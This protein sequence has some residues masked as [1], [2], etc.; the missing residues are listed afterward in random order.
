MCLVL[1]DWHWADPLVGGASRAPDRTDAHGCRSSSGAPAGPIRTPRRRASGRPPPVRAASG[2]SRS[3][4]SRSRR[5]K[6]TSWSRACS[7]SMTFRRGC[8]DLVLAK[9]EGNPFFIEEVVRSLVDVGAIVRDGSDGRWKT[10]PAVELVSIPPTLGGVITARFDRLDEDTKETLRIAAV[11]GRRFPL[12]GVARARPLAAA[13][14]SPGVPLRARGDPREQG[15]GRAR[16]RLQARGHPGGDLRGHPAPSP[17]RAPPRCRRAVRGVVLGSTRRV[18][19]PA[20]APLRVRR[21]VA[22]G[23]A[24][25]AGGGR[26]RRPPRRRRRGARALPAG[27]RG[28]GARGRRRVGRAAMGGP[29]AEDGGGAVPKR[30]ARRGRGVPAP[31]DRPAGQGRSRFAK[32]CAERNP[33]ADPRPGVAPD[34]TALP[35]LAETELRRR[36]RRAR[37]PVR[38]AQLGRLLHR[39]RAVRPRRAARAEPLR[40]VR[41]P[42]RD[43]ARVARVRRALRHGPAPSAGAPLPRPS[44]RARR[45]VRR[46]AAS[47]RGVPPP[48]DARALQRGRLGRRGRA[49]PPGRGVVPRRRRPAATRRGDGAHE[50]DA[51]RARR[52]RRESS[53]S[54]RRPLG[55]GQDADDRQVWGWGIGEQGRSLCQ[56]GRLDESAEATSKA[57][58]LLDSIPD[59]LSAVAAYGDLARCRLRQGRLEE[60]L[61][62]AEAAHRLVVEQRL[63]AFLCSSVYLARAETLLAAAD[64]DPSGSRSTLKQAGKATTAAVRQGRL[65]CEAQAAALRC[66]GTYHWLHGHRRRASRSWKRS[67]AVARRIGARNELA[68]TSLE[69]GSRMDKPEYLADAEQLLSGSADTQATAST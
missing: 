16:V 54:R 65:D 38:G 29:R 6:A 61:V 63:R 30:R 17:R 45:G 67:L 4:S 7:G 34:R 44:G 59:H 31:R 32:R 48:R 39:P 50:R 56:S 23:R 57:I 40:A 21:G 33:V 26:P 3:R 13:R 18:L 37:R 43:R 62:L 60:A 9:A 66:R 68:L 28:A 15:G 14:R 58:E 55:L 12:L 51:P 46:P 1:E 11:I 49:V 20:R 8:G 24:L 47:R 64:A 10:T 27:A 22:E 69:I 25:P 5:P 52:A 35:R 19:Q 41:L 2:T 53:R 36:R 42:D